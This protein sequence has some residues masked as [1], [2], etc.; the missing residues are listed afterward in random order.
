M[1]DEQMNIAICELRGWRYNTSNG[2]WYLNA[3]ERFQISQAVCAP[4]ELPNHINGIE[5]LGHM[6][7]AEK[8]LDEEDLGGRYDEMLADVMQCN[9]GATCMVRATARQRAEAMLRTLGKWEES[10]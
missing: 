2:Y 6:H 3:S 4:N 1:T 9:V 5:A 10:Q 8:V 7:E